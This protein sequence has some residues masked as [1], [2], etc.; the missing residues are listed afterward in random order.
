MESAG[1]P[2]GRPRA[3]GDTRWTSETRPEDDAAGTG[4]GT[5][6]EE[7]AHADADGPADIGARPGTP[8]TDK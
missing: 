5:G 2:M 3:V 6:G 8:T 7:L 1:V 4:T